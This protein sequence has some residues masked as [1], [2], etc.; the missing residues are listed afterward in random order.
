MLIKLV[1]VASLF[2]LPASGVE[3]FTFAGNGNEGYTGDGGKAVDAELNQPFGVVVGPAGN[4]FFCDTE[5]HVIRRIDRGTGIIT[6]VVGLGKKG[7]SGDGGKALKATLNEPYEVRFHP[8][9]GMWWVERM[10]HVVRKMDSETGIVSTVAGTGKEGFSGDGGSGMKAMMNQPHSIQFD[11]PGKLLYICDIKNHRIRVLDIDSGKIDTFCGN[12]KPGSTKDGAKVGKST[13]LKGAP[14]PRSFPG[15]GSLA[16]HPRGQPGLPHR[17]ENRAPPPRRRDGCERIFRK[18]RPGQGRHPLR[19]KGSRNLP[20]RAVDLPGRYGITHRPRHRYYQNPAHTRTH[21][22]RWEK[23]RRP[24]PPPRSNAAW[25]VSTASAP[26]PPTA[27]S[28]SA[29]AK[30]TK[31]A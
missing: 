1:A 6:T 20:G 13:P 14:R 4:V 12:G 19:P 27:T 18:R 9:G 22:R 11:K 21:R 29:I 15:R 26:T 8:D 5:N 16:R 28:T 10:N 30:P 2:A 24:T 31:S 25:P 23:R 17:Y 3:I 7:Y